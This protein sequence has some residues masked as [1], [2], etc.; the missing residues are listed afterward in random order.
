MTADEW[1][2]STDSA[3]MLRF[4]HENPDH[5]NITCCRSDRKLRLF[6]C[7]CGRELAKNH[8]NFSGMSRTEASHYIAAF[9][10]LA[11]GAGTRSAWCCCPSSAGAGSATGKPLS[12]TGRPRYAAVAPGP[13]WSRSAPGSPPRSSRWPAPRMTCAPLTAPLTPC[14]WPCWQTPWKRRGVWTN[15][16]SNATVVG[17]TPSMSGTT[18]F[19]P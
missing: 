17:R 7:A 11:D 8:L 13:T 3:R 18:L 4:V 19:R 12:G 2:A 9:E 14:A 16:A 10:D 15:G 1:Q 6:A 5:E